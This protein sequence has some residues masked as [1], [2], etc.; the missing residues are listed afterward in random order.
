[1]PLRWSEVNAK[2]DIRSYTIENAV[3]RMKKLKQD[4][5]REVL[6][7]MPDLSGVL[8]RLTQRG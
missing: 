2:L 8:E 5:L 6:T 1:M 3:A 7:A 4:P